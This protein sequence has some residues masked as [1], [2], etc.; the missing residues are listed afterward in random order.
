[1]QRHVARDARFNKPMKNWNLVSDSVLASARQRSGN[2]TDLKKMES[3]GRLT[4]GVAH[5]LQ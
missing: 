2:C 5:E 4:G 1:M 3:I